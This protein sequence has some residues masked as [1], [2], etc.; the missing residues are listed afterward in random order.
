VVD[1]LDAGLPDDDPFGGSP[2]DGWP[3]LPVL[4]DAAA[5]LVAEG[6]A[7]LLVVSRRDSVATEDRL[8]GRPNPLKGRLL[9][10]HLPP[11]DE[12]ACGELVLGIGTAMGMGFEPA[13]LRA[14]YELSGGHPF[15]ARQVGS[16]L[17]QQHPA[18]PVLLGPRDVER[19]GEGWQGNRERREELLA[20]ISD[21]PDACRGVLKAVARTSPDPCSRSQVRALLADR[22]KAAEADRG[23]RALVAT[24]LLVERDGGLHLTVG[25]LRD[26]LQRTLRRADEETAMREASMGPGGGP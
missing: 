26:W 9:A 23:V 10:R 18:R 22:F 2:A 7:A 17:V 25:L 5:R 8:G 14:V 6:Q 16:L 4:L 12:A 21:L 13:A 1:G 19:A 24:G 15:L 20:L 11:L 3:G